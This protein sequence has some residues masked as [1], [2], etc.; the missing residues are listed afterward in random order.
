MY[1]ISQSARMI[2][3]RCLNASATRKGTKAAAGIRVNLLTNLLNLV[4]FEN[5]FKPI[6]RR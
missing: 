2:F 5:K 1:S 3:V 6:Y 4:C